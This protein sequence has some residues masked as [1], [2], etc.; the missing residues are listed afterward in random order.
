MAD[1]WIHVTIEVP[2][3]DGAAI[4]EML[5]TKANFRDVDWCEMQRPDF[6]RVSYGPCPPRTESGFTNPPFQEKS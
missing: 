5:K 4:I 2:A 1:D 3:D 6:A